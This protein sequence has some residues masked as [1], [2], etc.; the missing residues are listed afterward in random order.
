M[1]TSWN[2]KTVEEKQ[3]AERLFDALS[4]M[5]Q[6]SRAIHRSDAVPA[7]GFA[8]IYAFANDPHA[9]MT[10][11][12]SRALKESARLR[13]D[14]DALMS[15]TAIYQ[16]PRVAA[17]SSGMVDQREG[18]GFTLRLKASRSGQN[19]LYIILELGDYTQQE[20]GALVLKDAEG[21]YLKQPLPAP[22]NGRIQLIEEEGSD[23]VRALRD[24]KTELYLQ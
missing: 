11:E 3:A 1:T 5:D 15:R 8:Q 21:L 10:P 19:Q 13:R 23:L 9:L 6:I 24:V 16:F 17:A 14:L 2:G 18:E 12:I 22:V 7:I 4:N 20:P